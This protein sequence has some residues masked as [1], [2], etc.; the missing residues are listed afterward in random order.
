MVPVSYTHLDVYKR[1]LIESNLQ[2]VR[3]TSFHIEDQDGFSWSKYPIRVKIVVG[4]TFLEQANN[5]E[6]LG[7]TDN[8]RVLHY[9][10]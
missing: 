6:Y 7:I 5:L 9:R 2:E 1:Q 3:I 8:Y 4:G 10:Q